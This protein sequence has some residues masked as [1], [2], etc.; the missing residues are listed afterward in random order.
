[1]PGPNPREL[2][3]L[4]DCA[5]CFGLCCVALP[6]SASADFAADKAAG[7]PCPNLREDFRCGIHAQLRQRGYPGCTV[8]DCFGAGQKVSQVTFAGTSW[9]QAPETA[10]EMY[11]VFPVVRQLH[12]LLW[13]LAEALTLEA[14][15]PIH[16]DLRQALHETERL[17][18]ESAD[19]LKKLD[20]V[21]H[22]TGVN[23]LLLR[24]SELV[25]AGHRGK[26]RR[27]ADLVGARLGGADLRGADLRGAYLIGADLRGAD[28][29]QADLIGADLRGADLAGADLTGS[30]FLTQAQLNAAKGDAATHLSASLA[31]PAHW[32]DTRTEPQPRPRRGAGDR[33]TPRATGRRPRRRR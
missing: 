8:Y 30:I 29:R 3:L 27:G 6:F 17:T 24:V 28:L 15:G 18:R 21:A 12:E 11:A 2:G 13:Y 31:R 14:A 22:R 5:N 1:M 25:R 20:L 7:E 16:A 10:R 23:T 4:A 26:D 19:V 33:A 32:P 9:R